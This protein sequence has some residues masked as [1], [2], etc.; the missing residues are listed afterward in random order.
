MTGK[1]D[2]GENKRGKTKRNSAGN[3]NQLPEGCVAAAISFTGPPDACRLAAVSKLFKSAAYYDA[4]WASFL[5]PDYRDIV[6]NSGGEG[7]GLALLSISK[8]DLFFYLAHHGL[9]IDGF[10]KSF[11]LD[12]STGKKC[13]TLSARELSIA[14][15]NTPRYWTFHPF[16]ES[17]FPEVAELQAVCWLEIKGTL[18]ASMLSP[19]SCYSAYFVFKFT[20]E[21]YGFYS[22]VQVTV[23]AAAPVPQIDTRKVYL[24]YL[25]GDTTNQMV[26]RPRRMIVFN[27][28]QTPIFDG[29]PPT[30]MLPRE[31]LDGWLEVEMGVLATGGEGED[32][33]VEMLVKEVAGTWKSGLI[34]EGI[35]IRPSVRM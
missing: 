26:P 18:K 14:W 23:T 30:N 5:P 3:F 4:V 10:T 25:E 13:F 35:E 6:A 32:G 33:E 28:V 2:D 31:R 22:P 15:G 8:R 20:E 16:P 21:A 24:K 17:R 34:V 11:F 1:T 29:P 19:N 27:R 7:E 9:L 12:K